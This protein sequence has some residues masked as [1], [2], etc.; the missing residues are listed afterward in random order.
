MPPPRPKYDEPSATVDLQAPGSVPPGLR[1]RIGK[2]KIFRWRDKRGRWR[3]WMPGVLRLERELGVN[4]N[5][6]EGALRLLEKE[7]WLV[8]AQEGTRVSL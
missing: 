4:R 2:G 3:D 8:P 7:G 5:T 1:G 6:L